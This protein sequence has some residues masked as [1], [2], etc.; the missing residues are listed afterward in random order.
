M[1]FR[2]RLEETGG[3]ADLLTFA[4]GESVFTKLSPKDLV[5]IDARVEAL[6]T[7]LSLKV[8]KLKQGA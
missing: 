1:D 7:E 8:E 3:I 4:N 6:I 2:L 5:A